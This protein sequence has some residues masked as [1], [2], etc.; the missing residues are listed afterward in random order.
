DKLAMRMY[1]LGEQPNYEPSPETCIYAHAQA[2][3]CSALE[4]IYDALLAEDGHALIYFPLYN[5]GKLSLDDVHHMLTHPLALPGLSDGGAHV[6][7]ICDA[8][9]PTFLLTHW[10]RDRTRGRIP[11][12]KLVKMQAFDTARYIGLRDRGALAPGQRADINIIDYPNLRL[13]AP[14]MHAD[15]PAGGKRLLQQAHGYVATLVNGQIIADQGQITDAR[16]GHL[17]RVGQ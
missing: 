11:L 10:G 2:K 15:L 6:G 17:V 8:S 16:P 12:E 7:T 1:N 9:F 3:N 5:Y 4:A 13:G 14:S